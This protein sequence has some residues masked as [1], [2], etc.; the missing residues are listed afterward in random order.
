MIPCATD[1]NNKYCSEYCAYLKIFEETRLK[2]VVGYLLM[3]ATQKKKI[4][5]K[6]RISPCPNL[7]YYCDFS[8]DNI[9]VGHVFKTSSI[10]GARQC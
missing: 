1:L 8:H 3:R 10:M 7:V 4:F 6:Q 9:P 5:K 2:A